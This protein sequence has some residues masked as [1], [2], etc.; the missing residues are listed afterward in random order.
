MTC[1]F[2]KNLTVTLTVFLFFCLSFWL[3]HLLL[4][5][6]CS[7]SRT[8][9]YSLISRKRKRSL[10]QSGVKSSSKISWSIWKVGKRILIQTLRNGNC[11][12]SGRK[13]T[14]ELLVFM[15]TLCTVEVIIY[16]S[17]KICVSFSSKHQIPINGYILHNILLF[18]VLEFLL[19]W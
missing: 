10:H 9:H 18:F 2:L 15:I 12:R 8:L 7:L 17:L 1:S 19:L 3:E 13:K 6:I 14:V 4:E 5:W 16:F 11:Y